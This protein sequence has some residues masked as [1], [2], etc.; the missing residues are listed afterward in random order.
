M[1]EKIRSSHL[2]RRAAVYLR[3]STLKQVHHHQESTSRQYALRQRAVDLGWDESRVDVIDDDLGQSGVGTEWREGFQRLAE[4]VAHGHVGAIFALEVSRLSRSSADWHQLLQLCVL[5]DVLLIDE[6]DVYCPR[7]FNDKLLLGLKGTM[8]DAEQYWMRLRLEGGRLHKA[9]RGDLFMTP[10]SGYEWDA[11][12]RRFRFDPDEQ[13]QRAV[14]LVFERFR[15]DGTA[16]GVVRYF[17]RVGLQLPT[18]DPHRQL[19]WDEPRVSHVLRM[20]HNP[21]YAGTYVFGRAEERM[22]LVDGKLRRRHRT[23][24]A[25]EAWKVCLHDHHPAYVSWEEFMVNQRTLHDHRTQLTSAVSRGAA[26]EGRA[27][28]QGLLLCGRCGHRM[29]VEYRAPNR[30]GVYVCSPKVGVQRCW[31]VPAWAVDAAVAKLFLEVMT[32]PEIELG[33]AVVRETERQCG[34]ID[35]QWRLRLE[36]ARYAAQLAERRYK[37]VDPD[38]RVIARTLEREWNDRLVELEALDHEHRQV[39][40][41]ETLSLTAAD[42]VRILALTKDLPAVWN[43][44]TT[45]HAERKNLLRMVVQEVTLTPLEGPPRSTRIQVLWATGATNDVTVPRNDKYISQATPAA[46]LALIGR[47]FREQETDVE[48]A[49]VLHRRGLK[50]GH[51]HG[52]DFAAVRRVRYEYGWYRAS[53]KARR[54]PNRRADG[55]YSVHA[56]AALLRVPPGVVRYWARKGVLKPVERGGPGR[57]HWFALDAETIERMTKVRATCRAVHG[58]TED[59]GVCEE[60]RAEHSEG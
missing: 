1:N 8:S 26:R 34:E 4:A 45:T 22:G 50:T 35:R 17:R 5:A 44:S 41:R 6:Q 37:A 7:D 52:W 11:A 14:R 51:D 60:E 9:R 53:P 15:L 31:S 2:E 32:P 13:V 39:R 47:L 20:L 19:C 18:R 48:I 16:Y 46:A 3:Q 21:V 42:R 29:H 54:I 58:V 28:L 23:T 43:S 12:T 10:P 55:L 49:A 36:R 27:L 38:N 25:Q 40:E 24:F 59:T 30:R 57:P 56:V 33:L